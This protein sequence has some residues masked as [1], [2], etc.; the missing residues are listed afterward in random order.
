MRGGVFGRK[1][2][3]SICVSE[4]EPD[5]LA[6]LGAR[7]MEKDRQMDSLVDDDDEPDEG[8]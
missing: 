7:T 8:E 2:K 6:R 1:R 3:Q 5:S 4:Q